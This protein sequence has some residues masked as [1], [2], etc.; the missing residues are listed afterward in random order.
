MKKPAV[1]G[2]TGVKKIFLNI[3]N[4]FTRLNAKM[5]STMQEAKEWLID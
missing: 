2:L 1:L 5:C 3:V 4:K